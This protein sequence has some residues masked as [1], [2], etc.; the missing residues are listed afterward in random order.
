MCPVGRGVGARK[1]SR[2]PAPLPPIGGLHILLVDDEADAREPMAYALED[3]GARV[4]VVASA[5]EALL[6]IESEV[7][8]VLLT[9]LAMPEGD[10]YA[11]IR[12]VRALPP[13]RGGRLPA[14]ALTA[15]GRAEDKVRALRAGFQLHL[16]KPLAPAD[17]A[18]AVAVLAGRKADDP[19]LR[20]RA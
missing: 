5:R 9:D 19:A 10:G 6:A 8:D 13:D 15:E 3:Y 1:V 20:R 16:A 14:A 18:A 2:A 11:L 7:P 17:V 4:T 12:R